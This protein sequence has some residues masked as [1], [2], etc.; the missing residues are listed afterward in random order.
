MRRRAVRAVRA[1]TL[2]SWCSATRARKVVLVRAAARSSSAAAAHG[3][4]GAT[5][6]GAVEA[7]AF[8]G[9]KHFCFRSSLNRAPRCAATHTVNE[10]QTS[11]AGAVTVLYNLK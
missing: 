2:L 9:A 11:K 10:K 6:S 5:Q 4:M 8:A 3:A 7:A 1:T